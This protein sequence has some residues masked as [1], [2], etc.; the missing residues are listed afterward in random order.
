MGTLVGFFVYSLAV[1]ITSILLPGIV[2]ADFSTSLIVALVLGLV[3]TFIKPVFLFLT[4]PITILTFGLFVL[5][6]NALMVLLV[7]SLV[8]G[9]EVKSFWW[10]LLFSIVLTIVSSAIFSITRT[11]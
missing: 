7:S 8:P 11:N 1:Y 3:N 4:F 5:V 9:F 2:L 10:G 6:I